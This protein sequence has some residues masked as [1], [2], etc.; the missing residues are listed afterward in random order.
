MPSSFSQLQ[1]KQQHFHQSTGVAKTVTFEIYRYR[2][3]GDTGPYVEYFDIDTEKCGFMVLDALLKIKNEMDSTLTF[4]RSCREGIC[5]SCAMNIAG[6]NTLACLKRID[7]A[8]AD[9][10]KNTIT[11]Y[12]LP[13]LPVLKD[14][15]PDMSL[16]YAHHASVQPWLKRKTADPHDKEIR[17][18]IADRERLDGLYECILCACCTTSCPS[19]WW[20]SKDGYLG[21]AALMAAYRWIADSRDEYGPERLQDLLVGNKHTDLRLEACH[22]IMNCSKTCP[23][24]LQPGKSIAVMRTMEPQRYTEKFPPP[25]LKGDSAK[26][27][28]TQF[29]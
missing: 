8:L 18:S 15:V 29:F 22:Q 12:P 26:E 27:I 4:R 3:D 16:F 1:G 24:H 7:E 25:D 11:V 14:L 19:Y 6:R 13:H 2:P 23:K 9:S 28:L 21:P 5:G 20:N 10:A 17:Q